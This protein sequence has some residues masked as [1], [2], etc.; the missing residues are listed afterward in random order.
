MRYIVSILI[1]G[2]IK[3]IRIDASLAKVNR[4]VRCDAC[5]RRWR[6]CHSMNRRDRISVWKILRY[7]GGESKHAVDRPVSIDRKL[8]S[9]GLAD[10]MFVGTDAIASCS[11]ILLRSNRV[12]GQ[13]RSGLWA[14]S[15]E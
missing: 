6:T 4:D 13:Q 1:A 11:P 12:V 15:Y 5:I 7:C 3:I 10:M 9:R 8:W 2:N 14:V